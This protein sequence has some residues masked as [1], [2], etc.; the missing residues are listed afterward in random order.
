M[1]FFYFFP[2]I[3]RGCIKL[4]KSD[5]INITKDFFFQINAIFMN[6]WPKKMYHSFHK[7]TK[8]DNNQKCFLSST[9]A[10]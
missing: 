10:Y 1:Y 5:I 3:Q 2:H 4:S 7:K 6:Y 9:S 8:M